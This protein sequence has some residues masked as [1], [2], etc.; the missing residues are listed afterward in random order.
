MATVRRLREVHI[1]PDGLGTSLTRLAFLALE[2]GLAEA[3]ALLVRL[4]IMAALAV[5][6]AIALVAALV[7]LVVAAVAPLFAVPWQHLALAGGGV[8]L[9]A[10]IAIAWCV[11]RVRRLRWPHG[12][13]HSVEE[14]WRW[15]AAQL[16]SRLT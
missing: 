15:L 4:A 14:T 11:M 7:V 16:K 6:A 2:L 9:L 12:T 13:V 8:A 3:R 5:T 10:T 1:E